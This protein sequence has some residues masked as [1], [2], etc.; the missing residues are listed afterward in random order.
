MSDKQ[1]KY[2]AKLYKTE[3]DWRE[4]FESKPVDQL[5]EGLDQG[6][7][8]RHDALVR[9]ILHKKGYD[10]ETIEKRAKR[11]H[12]IFKEKMRREQEEREKKRLEEWPKKQEEIKHWKNKVHRQ[13]F[14]FAF[15]A[16]FCFFLFQSVP[17]V[18]LK[19]KIR[20]LVMIIL[21]TIWAILYLFFGMV[22]EQ[23]TYEVDRELGI[24]GDEIQKNGN[25]W[26]ILEVIFVSIN[27]I[28]FSFGGFILIFAGIKIYDI[29]DWWKNR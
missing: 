21:Y 15:V 17:F 28:L 9:D 4:H 11:L 20:L 14:I 10:D 2:K 7:V 23:K 24:S 12:Q 3:Q 6:D 22:Q 27:T 13:G 5:I 1:K 8:G 26:N 19:G 25:L 16:L 29:I 18:F